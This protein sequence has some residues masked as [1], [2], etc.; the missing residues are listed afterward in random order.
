MELLLEN[1]AL[2][3]EA[4]VIN[5]VVSFEGA[6]LIVHDERAAIAKSGEV[7]KCVFSDISHAAEYFKKYGISGKVCLLNAPLNAPE[8]FGFEAEACKTFAYLSPMPPLPDKSV[9]IKR[10]A[11]SL[12]ETV[13]SEYAK[14]GAAGYTTEQVAELMRTKGVFGAIVDGKLAGFI[15]RHSDGNMGMLEVYENFRRR[16]L[17]MTLT[18]FMMAYIMTFGR[19]PVCDVFIK[20]APSIALQHKLGM[21]E[22][23]G[24]TFWGTLDK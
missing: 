20:N 15:G 19:T 18:R 24:Y 22:A 5:D 9:T 21:T 16:G 4:A 11:P 14:S 13:R 8:V 10:L 17:G 3:V 1:R 12:A 2:K 23:N 6:T 7:H